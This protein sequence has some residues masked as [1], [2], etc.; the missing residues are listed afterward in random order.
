MKPAMMI[1]VLSLACAC[2]TVAAQA[3]DDNLT[4][5]F[6]AWHKANPWYGADR[7]RTEFARNYFKQLVQERPDLSGRPLLDAVSRKVAETFGPAGKTQKKK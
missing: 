2:A 3:L 5:E 7:E 4:P 6:R 1:A